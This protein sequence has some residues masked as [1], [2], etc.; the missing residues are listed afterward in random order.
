MEAHE[1]GVPS[2][3]ITFPVLI[4]V[5]I[6]LLAALL[7]GQRT[8]SLLALIVLG[9]ALGT[10]L[11]S[12]MS[13]AGVTCRTK[14]DKQRLFPGETLRLEGEAV[15]AR[16]LPVW[17]QMRVNPDGPLEPLSKDESFTRESG[18]LWYEKARFR[19]ELIA[20]KRGVYSTGAPRLKVSDLL[21]FFPREK[22]SDPGP[23][24][25]IYPKLVPLKPLTFPKRDFFGTP[26]GKSPVQD[27]VY[28]LGT[29]D[30]QHWRPARFIHWKASARHSRLQEKVFEPTEQ[31]KVLLLLSVDEFAKNGAV[32]SFEETLEAI[33]SLAVQM[34]RDGCSVGLLTNARTVGDGPNM[35]P[36]TRNAQHLPALLEVLAALQMAAKED[37]LDKLLER[38]IP[39]RGISC[40][41]FSFREDERTMATGHYLRRRNIPAAFFVCGR[42][43]GSGADGECVE[44]RVYHLE[45][46]RMNCRGVHNGK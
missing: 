11:W 31:E 33:A 44:S 43:E 7:R 38:L 6:L 17:V 2:V 8:L 1:S 32:D 36:V 23:R 39:L 10:K 13:L 14:V 21:G 37:L 41:H 22:R 3:F 25:I 9:L 5:G 4:I 34:D 28:I 29:R 35:A 45:T 40:V 26:G 46:L 27:P 20:R 30:Y 19:W 12:R 24:V 18:L 15:N 42:R 16:F